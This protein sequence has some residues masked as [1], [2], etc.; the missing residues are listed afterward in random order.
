[1]EA[2]K[3]ID[4]PYTLNS[5]STHFYLQKENSD[6]TVSIN[7]ENNEI[8]VDQKQS[9]LPGKSRELWA[10]VGIAKFSSTNY[11]I[12]V[13]QAKYI[14][15]IKDSYIL[16]ISDVEFTPYSTKDDRA[17]RDQDEYFIKLLTELLHTGTFYFSYDYDLTHSMQ[18]AANFSDKQSA[19]HLWERGDYKYF[20][21]SYLS[22]D[23]M[24]SN[25]H[26]VI[27]PIINGF[28]QAEIVAINN[29]NVEYIL[30]SRRDHRRAGTRFNTRG[31]DELGHAVNFAETEQILTYNANGKVIVC[32][33]V[34]IRGSIPLIW[35]QKPNLS[36]SP[37]PKL[38]GDA[39]SSTNAA[40]QHFSE[41]KEIYN[42]IY[43]VNL[44]DK[45]GSQKMMGTALDELQTSLKDDKIKLTWFDFHDECKKMKYEN[46]SKLLI[47]I[48][49]EIDQYKWC[50]LMVDEGL[51]FTRAEVIQNQIG[52]I[53]TNCMDCLDRTNVVQS[54]LARNV[55]HRQL[56]SL[57]LSSKP[58][59]EAFQRLSNPLEECF[60]SFWTN[61]ADTLSIL[62]SGTPAL[63]TDFTRT[64]K[65]TIKG[66][67]N[68]G[69]NAI[70]RFGI[71]N[72]I[73]G[74]RQN[75]LDA[76]LGKLPVKRNKLRLRGKFSSI[77]AATFSLF[78]IMF[79][80]HLT[81]DHFGEG[82]GYWAIFLVSTLSL[83]KAMMLYGTLLIDKPI[84][85]S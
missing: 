29:T 34:Q 18:R 59:S 67:L 55:L 37:K 11:L 69:V 21:N 20:W 65:R 14:G 41:L 75:S 27:I 19:S 84:I 68:D 81:G 80:S 30:I 56:Y 6:T 53:R 78:V 4:P 73:D 36:W 25:A 85:N 10:F 82:W 24:N 8:L 22:E 42:E 3:V 64:G 44:I 39:S 15:R 79:M 71:N 52:V 43:L 13:T 28:I 7:R 38:I 17:D 1:M 62:Y 47:E 5:S 16:A 33:Y 48:D 2:R 76:F 63:K 23:F 61:N 49:G 70:Q 45:K 51:P 12:G 46:L 26:D 60:R 35:Q 50:Q 74:W 58:T 77:Y 54:V 32:S 40:N 9:N 31:L 66:S 83:G 57:K 72:F